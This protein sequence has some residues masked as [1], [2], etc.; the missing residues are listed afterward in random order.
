MPAEHAGEVSISFLADWCVALLW[1]DGGLL[2]TGCWLP[3]VASRSSVY[4][5]L[6]PSP[7]FPACEIICRSRACVFR[8]VTCSSII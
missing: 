7:T 3:G 8:A 6:S 2:R 1:P 4:P 5:Y